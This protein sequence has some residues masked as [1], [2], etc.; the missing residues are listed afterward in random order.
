MCVHVHMCVEGSVWKGVCDI[1]G[2]RPIKVVNTT[3]LCKPDLSAPRCLPQG[4]T[5][6]SPQ[7]LPADTFICTFNHITDTH[8]HTHTYVC[9]HTHTHT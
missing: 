9:I 3:A 2:H 8:T 5:W 7:K 1:T 4:T 6:A